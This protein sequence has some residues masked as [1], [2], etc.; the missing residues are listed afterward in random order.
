ML[1]IEGRKAIVTGVSKGI[2]YA[3]VK[4]LLDSGVHV[5][6]W[7][8][9]S[10]E[11][12]HEKFHFIKTDVSN[13]E[14]VYSSFEQSQALFDEP[15]DILINNA[16]LGFDG[17][18]EEMDDLQWK[19]MF[20]TNVHGVFFCSKA[21]IPGMKKAGIGHIVNIAS[22]AG[23]TGIQNMAGY[24]GTKFAVRGIS[25]SMFKELRD[26]G[27]KVTC[28]YPGSVQ[29][30]FFDTISS[31]TANENM[32]QPEDIAETI[33]HCLQSSPNY[34]HIDIEVRPLKPK[35]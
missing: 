14:N 35:G 20:D 8:R 32:M 22:I 12:N 18:I 23:I 28:I 31:V 30:G 9:T 24:C 11:I 1:S 6:G 19:T 27:I 13:A 34:H 3:T 7:G 17:K 21:V 25:H 29:T 15:I 10:P 26:F 33:V 5:V 2:G 4:S 16:G